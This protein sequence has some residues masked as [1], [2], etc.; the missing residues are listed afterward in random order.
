MIGAGK[1]NPGDV[2][3]DRYRYQDFKSIY[4]ATGSQNGIEIRIDDT[5]VSQYHYESETKWNSFSWRYKEGDAWITIQAL[6]YGERYA[7]KVYEYLCGKIEEITDP[8]RKAKAINKV[9]SRDHKL[10]EIAVTK[11]LK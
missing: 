9:S 4:E 1:I 7:T 11:K 6:K 10:E 5:S 8:K 3:V 2:D